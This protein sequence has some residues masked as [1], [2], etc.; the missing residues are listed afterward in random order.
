MKRRLDAF[1]TCLQANGADLTD[2]DRASHNRFLERIQALEKIPERNAADFEQ[3]LLGIAGPTSK[4]VGE[5]TPANGVLSVPVLKSLAKLSTKPKFLLL[6]RDPVD[7]M[8]SQLRMM[9][10]TQSESLDQAPQRAEF[11]LNAFLADDL[12]KLAVRHRYDT[13]IENVREAIPPSQLQLRF[14]ET[15]YCTSG[16]AS[17]CDFLGIEPRVDKLDERPHLGI[18]APL[19]L[20]DRQRLR[21]RLIDQYSATQAALGPLPPRWR[22][23]LEI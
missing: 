5:F 6:L 2:E 17:F 11:L 8:W 13:M 15:F 22:E 10:R 7:R 12:P 18:S 23:Q 16:L 14:Y 4:V 9:A 21:D 19:S 1:A 20:T 3:L